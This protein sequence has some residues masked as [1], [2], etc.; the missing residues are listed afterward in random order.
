MMKTTFKSACIAVL[1]LMLSAFVQAQAQKKQDNA[2]KKILFVVTSH[3]TKGSTGEQTGYLLAF[4]IFAV[5]YRT[6]MI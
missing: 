4:L 2:K 5:R 6:C 1:V 3:G